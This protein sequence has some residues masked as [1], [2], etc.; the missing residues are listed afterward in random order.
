M[1][2]VGLT[3]L[4]F[5]LLA[6]FQL[7]NTKYEYRYLSNKSFETGSRIEYKVH[8]GWV[9]A[10]TATILLDKGVHEVN[11]RTCYKVDVYGNSS[12]LL[13]CVVKIRNQWGTY[14]DTSAFISHRFYRY[15]IE[16][17]Y[18]KNERVHFDHEKKLA[19]VERLSDDDRE[20]LMETAK[21]KIPDKEYLTVD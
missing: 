17:N 6:S 3:G 2:K 15:I 11:G 16:D 5:T 7:K 13:D 20:V 21:F 14:I 10:G 8:F 4:A 18:K 1:K 12:G 9:N 19:I